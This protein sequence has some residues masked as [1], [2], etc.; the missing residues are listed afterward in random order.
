MTQDRRYSLRFDVGI[1]V[2]VVIIGLTAYWAWVSY[3]SFYNSSYILLMDW[4]SFISMI[5]GVAIASLACGILL[6]FYSFIRVY[7]QVIGARLEREKLKEE[8]KKELEPERQ[9]KEDT[10]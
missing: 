10:A 3:L 7:N 9:E 6:G 4:N 1:V 8:T 5:L 2:I